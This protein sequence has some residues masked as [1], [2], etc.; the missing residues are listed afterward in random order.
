MAIEKNKLNKFKVLQKI[1]KS[2]STSCCVETSAL[3]VSNCYT[4]YVS[5]V[6]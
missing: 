4:Y 6:A 2:K 1:E 5:K 3:Y